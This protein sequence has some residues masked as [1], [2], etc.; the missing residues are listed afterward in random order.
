[1]KLPIIVNENGDVSI[2]RH[3]EDACSH[4]EAIDVKNNEYVAYDADG[5]Q[6]DLSTKN[7]R[8]ECTNLLG[9][10]LGL[11]KPLVIDEIE[12][13]VISDSENQVSHAGDL[14][15]LLIKYLASLE[16]KLDIS[17]ENDL[18]YLIEEALK[19]EDAIARN[20]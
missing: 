17:R 3:L 19:R 1:M 6:L 16:V 12:V 4:M 15:M 2:Y 18:P 20:R 9:R 11:G 13:V 5:Y 10:I 7:I 14:K 8:N